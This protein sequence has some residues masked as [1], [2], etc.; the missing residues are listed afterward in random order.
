MLCRRQSGDKAKS[1]SQVP[2]CVVEHF[3]FSVGFVS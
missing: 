2:V 1:L 3:V